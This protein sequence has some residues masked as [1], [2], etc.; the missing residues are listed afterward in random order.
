MIGS[1]RVIGFWMKPLDM[2]LSGG[3]SAP[4]RPGEGTTLRGHPRLHDG[5]AAA[6]SET[7]IT[8]LV[9]QAAGEIS[10][11]SWSASPLSVATPTMGPGLH[12]PV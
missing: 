2:L 9:D 4:S 12:K 1:P 11:S 6:P 10:A 5:D 8:D 3:S 7:R